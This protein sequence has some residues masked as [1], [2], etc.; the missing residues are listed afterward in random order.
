M[1]TCSIVLNLDND[2]VMKRCIQQTVKIVQIKQKQMISL[3]GQTIEQYIK[4]K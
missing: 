3:D 4:I 2:E 1:E